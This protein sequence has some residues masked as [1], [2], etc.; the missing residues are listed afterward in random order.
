MRIEFRQS[1]G[2]AGIIRP[3][4]PAIDTE[5][6]PPEEARKWHDL[7]AASHFFNLPDK[8][9]PQPG[10]DAFSYTIT[11]HDGG[12][13]HTVQAQGRTA[14]PGLNALI[15]ELRRGALPKPKPPMGG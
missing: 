8:S 3:P 15:E 6:L 11:V 13:S 12:R 2:V 10:G 9:P 4:P 5:S 14:S 1:G 7:V